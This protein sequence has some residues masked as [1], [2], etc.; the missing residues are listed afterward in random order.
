MSYLYCK[1]CGHRMGPSSSFCEKCGVAIAAAEAVA[2][3]AVLSAALKTNLPRQG[4]RL[5][6]FF[7]SQAALCLFTLLVFSGLVVALAPAGWRYASL[8]L[9]SGSTP[10]VTSSGTRSLGASS[11]PARCS[12]IMVIFSTAASVG[13]ISEL[14]ERLD[15]TIAFGPNENGAFELSVLPASAAGVTE[16]LNRASDIV[17]AASLQRRCL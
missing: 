7:A 4:N 12:Q 3:P 15:T 17:V 13:R 2:V 9:K 5:T 14:L 11:A 10:A 8:Q 1:S 6:T 16:A